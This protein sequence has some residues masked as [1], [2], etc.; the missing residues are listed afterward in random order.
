VEQLSGMQDDMK[1]LL[2]AI[3][4]GTVFLDERLRIKRFTR[5]AGR[6]YRL[7]PTDVGRPLADI[8]SSLVGH[9]LLPD[10]QAVL[11]TLVPVERELRCADGAW[12]LARLL[13][14]R[15]VDNAIRGVVL[16][17]TDITKRVEAE[18]AAQAGRE[19]AV[20][21][22]D[23]V[24]EPLLVLDGELRVVSA[25]RSFHEAFGTTPPGT[26]GRPIYQ[27][28]D[29]RWDLP[30]L[31]EL[32][33]RVLPRDQAFEGFEVP[34]RAPDGTTRNTYVDGRRIA[35]P[36]GGAELILLAFRQ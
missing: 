36:T 9:D 19:L 16:T 30:A 28:A 20:R 2:E 29:G 24:R 12:F 4:V 27:L 15:T 25:S 34:I 22:V 1:N 13:P 5:E 35:A 26:V 14:Y 18:A 10:A 33:E 11:D 32:L 17:F 23:T 31:R 6:V 8:K 7:V 3:S 21:I